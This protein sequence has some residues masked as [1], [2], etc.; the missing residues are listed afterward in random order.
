[1]VDSAKILPIAAILLPAMI[2]GG[3]LVRARAYVR[4]TTL[5]AP[6]VWAWVALLSVAGVELLAAITATE[7]PP[8]WLNA[9]R[10]LAALATF[11]PVMAVLGAKRPQDRAWQII[12]AS[13]WG[14]LSLPALQDL[15]YH[16]GQPVALDPA[17]RGFL[18]ILVAVG[19]V[20]YLPTRFWPSSILFGLAQVVLM[21]DYLPIALPIYASARVPAAL[22]LAALAGLLPIL[23]W[24][25]QRPAA[26]SLDG[27]W[28]DFR[29]AYG[30]LW[31]VRIRDRASGGAA[32]PSAGA[33]ADRSAE[34]RTFVAHLQRFVSR[35]WI[36]ARSQQ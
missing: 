8:R 12:V 24:P 21:T 3:V 36:A 2:V 10:C 6:C 33:S 32:A 25:G 34:E 15:L 30:M 14:V 26:D 5:A 31:G 7:G 1:M 18:T 4:G 17:W 23:G 13:L 22:T 11:C 29:N 28:R 19:W 16:Y 9:A 27:L 35:E 20:N